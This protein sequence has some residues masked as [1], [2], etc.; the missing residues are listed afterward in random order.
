MFQQ[1]LKFKKME[2]KIK[3]LFRVGVLILIGFKAYAQGDVVNIVT[4]GNREIEVGFRIA[5]NPKVID[6]VIPLPEVQYPLLSLQ[7]QSNVSLDTIAAANVKLVEKLPQLY[8]SYAKV[9]IGSGLM[10]LGEVYYNSG[11]SRKYNYGAHLKHISAFGKIKDYAPAQY[12]RTKLN[13]FGGITEKKY[14]LNGDIFWQNRGLHHYG[15]QNPNADRDSIK[16]RFNELGGAFQFASHAKDSAHLNYTLGLNYRNFLEAKSD[17]DSL[18]AWRAK[19]NFIGVKSHFWYQMGKEVFAA[20]LNIS[21]NGYRYGEKDK[22]LSPVDSSRS[23]N[24][25]VIQLKPTITTFALNNKLKAEIG[26]DITLDVHDKTK[27]YVYPIAEVKYSL[28]NDIFIPYAG[29]KG[30]LKQNTYRD[31]SLVNEFMVSNIALKN[32]HNAIQFYGGFKGTLTKQIGFNI[33]GRFGNYKNKALFVTDTLLSNSNQFRLIYDTMNVASIEGS[34]FFQQSEKLKIDV[35]GRYNSYMA[36]NNTYAWNLPSLEFVLRGSYNLYD[37]FLVQLDLNLEGGR[38]ALVYQ[39]GTNTTLENN[40]FAQKLGFIA[41]ANL[42]V[43]Y[44]YNKRISAFLEFN[45]FAAQRYKRWYNYPVQGFQVLGGV[46]FR[47]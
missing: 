5:E 17:V 44:R 19:E 39:D 35:I 29:I 4:V 41:D 26:V 10:P 18:K 36:R 12:D 46:T 15:F 43:E 8:N 11:R 3:Q 28:F 31:L 38:K 1:I 7:Y 9:G 24:N 13:V 2:N 40:Q 16:N 21:Y 22:A 20:D 37:K 42:H 14:T 23:L 25:T 32:E 34:V 45:N 30:G 33:Q 27:L 47:F 6:T